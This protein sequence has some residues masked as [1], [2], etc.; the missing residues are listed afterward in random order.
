MN[1]RDLLRSVTVAASGIFVPKLIGPIYRPGRGLIVP[2][3]RPLPTWT[4]T[5]DST[6][7]CGWLRDAILQNEVCNLI[8]RPHADSW[9]RDSIVIRR[10]ESPTHHC[11]FETNK[12]EHALYWIPRMVAQ[13]HWIAGRGA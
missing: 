1:R 4:L 10:E 9:Y 8:W 7:T 3:T 11:T 13:S 5:A 6:V 12:V 2:S